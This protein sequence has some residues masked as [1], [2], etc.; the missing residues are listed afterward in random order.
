MKCGQGSEWQHLAGWRT[1]N[2]SKRIWVL[3]KI[4]FQITQIKEAYN[5]NKSKGVL[6][7]KVISFKLRKIHFIKCF[8]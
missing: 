2:S 7:T 3:T 4:C 1:T 6:K 5:K 8:L